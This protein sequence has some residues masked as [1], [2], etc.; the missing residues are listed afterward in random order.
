MYTHTHVYII[1]QMLHTVD[2]YQVLDG[3]PIAHRCWTLLT[4]STFEWHSA[5]PGWSSTAKKMA[6][7]ITNI[8]HQHFHKYDYKV[9]HW[10]L[11]VMRK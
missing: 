3:T 6:R 2:S 11:P 1:V 8:E 5:R 9:L 4:T 7:Y 10:C